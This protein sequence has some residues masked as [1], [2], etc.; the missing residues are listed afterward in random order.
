MI[1]IH[2]FAFDP[3]PDCAPPCVAAAEPP[4]E[5]LRREAAS[6]LA[7]ARLGWTGARSRALV[8]L[9]EVV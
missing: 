5:T 3:I 9:A 1:S 7:A 2:P 6:S 8:W 4:V